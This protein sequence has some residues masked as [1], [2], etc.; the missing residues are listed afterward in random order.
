MVD[1]EE[2]LKQKA[3]GLKFAR[4]LKA[5]FYPTVDDWKRHSWSFDKM[6]RI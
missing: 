1:W 6:V 2:L 3:E 4:K 5:D